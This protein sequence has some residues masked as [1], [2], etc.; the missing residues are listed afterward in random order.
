MDNDGDIDSIDI[1][2]IT[3]L[4]NRT[5]PPADARADADFN[6]IINVNDARACTLRCTRQNCAVQ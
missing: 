2:A 4:R 6:G 1:R 3:A 5:V